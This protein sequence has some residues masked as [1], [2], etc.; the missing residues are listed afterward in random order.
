M[1]AYLRVIGGVAVE[2]YSPPPGVAI[3]ACFPASVAA[4]FVEVDGV[5]P[6]PGVGWTYTGTPPAWA[7]PIVSAP[8]LTRAQQTANLL[9]GGLMVTSTSGGWTATFAV[10]ADATGNSVWT[11]ILAELAALTLSSGATFADG[12]S[13]V[14]WPDVTSTPAALSLHAMSPAVFTAFAKAIGLFIAQSRDYANGVSG[15]A[16]PATSTTIV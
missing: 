5:T 12:G 16:E 6:A 4:E 10:V 3:T 8:V 15:A 14:Q 2:V 9:A 13:T 1:S 7:A 11:M